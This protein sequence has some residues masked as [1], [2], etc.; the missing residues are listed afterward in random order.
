LRDAEAFLGGWFMSGI[1]EATLANAIHKWRER[2]LKRALKAVRSAG[3]TP[4]CV[5]V[6][7]RT[8]RII[9]NVVGEATHADT[10]E[11]LEKLV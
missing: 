4:S 9:V 1:Q 10:P 5:E 8:G 11:D 6:D 7:P 2:D 3:E